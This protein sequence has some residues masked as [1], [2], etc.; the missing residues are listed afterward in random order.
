MHGWRFMQ[1]DERL[2]TEKDHRVMAMVGM[3]ALVL[4]AFASETFLKCLI[5][6]ETGRK[7]SGHNLKD[8]FQKLD[9]PTKKRLETLWNEYASTQETFWDAAEKFAGVRAKR[10]HIGCLAEGN[11]GFVEMRYSYEENAGSRFRL[12]DFPR[13]LR[14]VILEKKPEWAR[15]GPDLRE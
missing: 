13:M 5:Y 10:D 14:T 3:P 8:L 2:Q 1:A 7:E 12:A 11:K 15:L 6:L 9:R 4:S